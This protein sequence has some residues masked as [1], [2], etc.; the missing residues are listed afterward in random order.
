MTKD[1]DFKLLK[2]QTCVLRVNIHCDGCKQKVKKILQRIEG[3]YQVIIDGEQQKVSVSGSVDSATLV[4]KLLRCGKHAELWSQKINQNQKQKASGENKIDCNEL[5]KKVKN[6]EN[7]K[8]K[9]NYP[10]LVSEED[11][12]FLGEDEGEMDADPEQMNL[13]RNQM[14]ILKQ[15]AEAA[16]KKGMM[17]NNGGNGNSG[18]KGNHLNQ[19]GVVDPRTLA[20]MKMNGNDINSMMNLAGFHGNG[21]A[22][23]GGNI[24]GGNSAAAVG[25]QNPSPV[26]MN[27]NGFN[28][29]SPMMMMNRQ[30]QMMYSRSPFVPPTTGYYCNYGPVPVPAVPYGSNEYGYGGDI[31]ATHMF[32]DE[33]T[34]SCSIM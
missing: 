32:S 29:Q 19:M 27:V 22:N 4:K 11:G 25:A 9:Q 30:P 5:G 31:P 6:L 2:I 15:Q 14:A 10:F 26:M 12:C 1:G 28:N 21:V 18:K 33:N 16:H 8:N 7:L 24:L 23:V 34:S 13:L 3:V 20:A 17:N